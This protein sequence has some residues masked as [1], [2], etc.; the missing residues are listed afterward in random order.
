MSKMK[1]EVEHRLQIRKYEIVLIPWK[2]VTG[3][4][5]ARTIRRTDNS[6]HGQFVARTIRRMD[7]SSHRWLIYLREIDDNI[8]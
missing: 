3:Q 6:S 4:F 2:W 5:V 8:K 1:R 7:N